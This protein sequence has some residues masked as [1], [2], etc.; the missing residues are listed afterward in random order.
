MNDDL[1]YAGWVAL[2]DE[3]QDAAY[4]RMTEEQHR[5]FQKEQLAVLKALIAEGVAKK[6]VQQIETPAATAWLYDAMRKLGPMLG[7]AG[8]A[9]PVVRLHSGM[10]PDW[11]TEQTVLNVGAHAMPTDDG[12]WDIYV[13]S[14]DGDELARLAVLLHELVHASVPDIE[15]DRSHGRGFITRAKRLG[16]VSPWSS[17]AIGPELRN[18]LA[19]LVQTDCG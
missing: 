11:V 19:A 12:S 6:R 16:F 1:T 5:A 13:Y 4:E 14:S 3:E 8:L 2:P 17:G 15:Y 18:R 9:L 7:E 10:S